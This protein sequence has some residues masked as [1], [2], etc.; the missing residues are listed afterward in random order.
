[1]EVRFGIIDNPLVPQGSGHGYAYQIL[2]GY[3]GKGYGG[4]DDGT[5]YYNGS[6]QWASYSAGFLGY[7]RTNGSG[8]GAN[9]GMVIR[10]GRR[11]VTR[12][13]MLR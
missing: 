9:I 4:Y 8:F 7:D 13:C 12:S 1:M 6:A 11:R 5:A 3:S 2:P 10:L